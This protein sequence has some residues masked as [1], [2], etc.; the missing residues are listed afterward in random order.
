MDDHELR[1]VVKILDKI[2]K[3]HTQIDNLQDKIIKLYED[4]ANLRAY[5]KRLKNQR[6][7]RKPVNIMRIH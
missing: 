3:K 1:K 4:I 2:N 7:R 6:N 5:E